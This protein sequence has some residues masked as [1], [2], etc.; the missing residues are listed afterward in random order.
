MCEPSILERTG[1]TVAEHQARTVDNFL[2][3][4]QIL[5][6]LVIPVLQGWEPDDYLRCA[7]LY[8]V[9]GVELDL[10]TFVGVGSV[11]RGPAAITAV[12]RALDPL[13]LRLHGFGI[14]GRVLEVVASMLVSADSTA[15]SLNARYNRPLPGCDH[16][17]CTNC[18]RYALWWRRKLGPMIEQGDRLAYQQVLA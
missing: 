6:P 7:D 15:W 3:L 14:K 9:A 18:M 12:L 5:G 17:H 10:E 11:V 16:R 2:R 8:D 13:E 4:R 1:L